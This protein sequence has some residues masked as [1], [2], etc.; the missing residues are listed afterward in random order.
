VEKGDPTDLEIHG[1]GIPE[2]I[3]H[4][5]A[6]KRGWKMGNNKTEYP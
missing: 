6:Q 4:V 1:D 5:P 2:T 3:Y